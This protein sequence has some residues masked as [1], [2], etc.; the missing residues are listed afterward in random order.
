MTWTKLLSKKNLTKEEVDTFFNAQP[1]VNKKDKYG[2]SYV[3]RTVAKLK[4][5]G[6]PIYNYVLDKIL[7]NPVDLTPGEGKQSAISRALLT[8]IYNQKLIDKSPVIE[9]GEPLLILALKADYISMGERYPFENSIKNMIEMFNKTPDDVFDIPDYQNKSAIYHLFQF[10]SISNIAIW[11]EETRMKDFLVNEI[12]QTFLSRNPDINRV[13]GTYEKT[14]PASLAFAQNYSPAIFKMLLKL[15]PDMKY[16]KEISPNAK[17]V[18]ES[19]HLKPRAQKIIQQIKSQKAPPYKWQS[20]CSEFGN[21]N[22]PTLQQLAILHGI[23]PGKMTKR[24][25]CQALAIQTEK[26]KNPEDCANDTSILGDD[27]KDIPAYLL[28]SFEEKGKRYCFNIVELMEYINKGNK[29]NPFTRQSLDIKKIKDRFEILKKMLNENA[30]GMVNIIEQ[31]RNNPI[32]DKKTILKLAITNLTAGMSYPP[33]VDQIM[34]FSNDQLKTITRYT[35]NNPIFPKYRG[36]ISL[37]NVM[38]FL[39]GAI[40][41]ENRDLKLVALEQYLLDTNNGRVPSSA[42]ASSSSSS[43]RSV[44]PENFNA[45]I[46]QIKNENDPPESQSEAWELLSAYLNREPTDREVAILMDH[47]EYTGEWSS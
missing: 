36:P 34:G 33:T 9:D 15:N 30:L 12:I 19:V 13:S 7:D 18:L 39:T 17:K 5:T 44:I 4:D 45:L 1:D 2:D 28:Y 38:S 35:N 26:L 46:E 11:R 32:M 23:K 31:I 43:A 10:L 24:Q 8:G 16:I 21:N 3:F 29:T 47:V 6:N 22:L 27:I 25:L 20:I 40:T 37:E 14:T 41:G 42:S